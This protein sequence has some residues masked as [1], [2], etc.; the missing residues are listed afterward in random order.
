MAIAPDPL[1][2]YPTDFDL[3]QLS[4]LSAALKNRLFDAPLQQQPSLSQFGWSVLDHLNI[5]LVDLLPRGLTA[6][7]VKQ[8]CEEIGR[9]FL[10]VVLPA[11]DNYELLDAKHVAEYLTVLNRQ[12]PD[13]SA[14]SAAYGSARLRAFS[15]DRRLVYRMAGYRGQPGD[16]LADHLIA[17]VVRPAVQAVTAVAAPS[18]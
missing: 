3:S 6:A 4:E 13:A 7:I 2:T 18:A 12:P 11:A 1:K 8:L 5:R 9:R 17:E 10:A 16:P 14:M 15:G